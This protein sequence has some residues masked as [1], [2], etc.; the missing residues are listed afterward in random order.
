[1]DAEWLKILFD[2][3]RVARTLLVCVRERLIKSCSSSRKLTVGGSLL[4]A[5]LSIETGR[6]GDGRADGLFEKD[7]VAR[8]VGRV[9][10]HRSTGDKK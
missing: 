3:A 10:L 2:G 9:G 6:H 4:L 5:D 7:R 8:A 1:M